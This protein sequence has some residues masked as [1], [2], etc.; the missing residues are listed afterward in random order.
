MHEAQAARDRAVGALVG[1]AGAHQL[2]APAQVGQHVLD[3]H[4]IDLERRRDGRG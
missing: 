4:R 1:A 2:A 3:L